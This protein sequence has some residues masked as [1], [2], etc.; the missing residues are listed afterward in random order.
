MPV[1]PY[2]GRVHRE[3]WQRDL[4]S[5]FCFSLLLLVVIA[6]AAALAAGMLLGGG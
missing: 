3:Q 2:S 1:N 6:T 5:G 4:R